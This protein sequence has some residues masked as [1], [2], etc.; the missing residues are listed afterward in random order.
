MILRTLSEIAGASHSDLR[1]SLSWWRES[2]MFLGQ[3][4][5]RGQRHQLAM[6]TAIKDEL[7]RADELASSV[8]THH[9]K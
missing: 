4:T 2:K 3:S 5:V 8:P 7:R 9:E 6:I 1:E